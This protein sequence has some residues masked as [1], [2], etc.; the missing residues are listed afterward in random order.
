MNFI[1]IVVLCTI[2]IIAISSII[3]IIMHYIIRSIVNIIKLHYA[4]LDRIL[5]PAHTPPKRE[6]TK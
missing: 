3:I 5:P 2:L 6:M 1:L 4:T